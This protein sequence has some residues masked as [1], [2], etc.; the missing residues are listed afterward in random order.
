MSGNYTLDKKFVSS[1]KNIFSDN[2]VAYNPYLFIMSF[3]NKCQNVNQNTDCVQDSKQNT[4][5]LPHAEPVLGSLKIKNGAIIIN[6]YQTFKNRP[7]NQ[8]FEYL[9]DFYEACEFDYS[10]QC[11]QNILANYNGVASTIVNGAFYYHEIYDEPPDVVV[12]EQDF[13]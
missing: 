3:C 12:N 5:C 6:F 1:L 4:Y 13:Y 7:L 2:K 11:N 9:A 10:V 8:F